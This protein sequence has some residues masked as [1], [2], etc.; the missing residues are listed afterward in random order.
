MVNY[1]I[2][3]LKDICTLNAIE[4]PSF[5]K[6]SYRNMMKHIGIK[7]GDIPWQY[8]LPEEEYK[9]EKIDLENKVNAIKKD[10]NYDYYDNVYSK[11]NDVFN[12]IQKA[13]INEEKLLNYIDENPTN[14][15]LQSF[16]FDRKGFCKK[17]PEYSLLD[18]S[19]GRMVIKDGPK[20]LNLE[21]KYRNILESRFGNDGKLWYLDFVSLEPRVLLSINNYNLLSIGHP[22]Q[23]EYI[24][25]KDI[26]EFTLKKTKLSSSLNR[27]M[28]KKIILWQCY[29][30]KK[31]N[32]LNFLNENK[33]SHPEDVYDIIE[34]FYGIKEL[35]YSINK[36]MIKRDNSFIIENF[37]GRKIKLESNEMYK[38]INFDIQSSAVD[39]AL[40]GFYKIIKAINKVK[41]ANKFL[42]PIFVLH[43]AMIIDGHNSLQ[44]I[45]PKLC[46][47]G[48]NDIYKLEKTK[49]WIKHEPFENTYN[50][51]DV[52]MKKS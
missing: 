34:E 31:E 6:D 15:L 26:Y 41:D 25:P 49:F 44:H 17:L 39:V 23:E 14:S 18:S 10:L 50:T 21:K 33:I 45:I 51:N 29:G 28:V 13:K 7:D 4:Y 35:K 20:F 36:K 11:T 27:D 52:Y 22:P 37:F 38:L 42:V 9:Q 32:I 12:S 5:P 24:I 19:T 48:S 2:N 47:I 3:Q 8:I 30:M 16:D 40:L 46:E 1:T 43:D